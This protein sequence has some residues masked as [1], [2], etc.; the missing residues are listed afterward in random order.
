MGTFSQR[1]A[2]SEEVSE[3]LGGLAGRNQRAEAQ[4]QMEGMSLLGDMQ[5][6]KITNKAYEGYLKK[7]K[8]PAAGPNWG[9]LAQPLAGL[10][11]GLFGGGGA[12]SATPGSLWNAGSKTD[13]GGVARTGFGYGGSFLS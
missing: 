2:G 4:L 6:Q 11:G 5:A 1:M 12:S 7:A 3:L 13:W 10:A 9:S 8:A